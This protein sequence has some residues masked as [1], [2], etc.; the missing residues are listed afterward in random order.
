MFEI[1]L[2]VGLVYVFLMVVFRL[3]G[4]RELG[5]L[6]P[7][8]LVTL[9]LIPETV[10]AG[11]NGEGS[12]T[13]GLVGAA[14]LFLLVI[15]TSLLAHRFT[16]F[17]KAVEPSPAVLVENGRL[18]AGALDAERI[19]PEELFSEM[20]KQGYARLSQIA[21]AILESGGDIAFVPMKRA[22][23]E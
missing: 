22:T 14:T 4:K 5:S 15:V 17:G 1:V 11:I 16:K 8:E 9:M 21:F 2:R 7:F 10:S 18:C 3:L 13:N 23:A 6:S 20:H 12:I 19:R